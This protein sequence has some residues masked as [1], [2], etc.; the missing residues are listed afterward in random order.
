MTAISPS[1]NSSS[2]DRE[3]YRDGGASFFRMLFR[4]IKGPPRDVTDPGITHE[5]TLI[6][7]LAWVGLG[8]DGLSSSAY[9]P[10]EAFRA[11]LYSEKGDNWYLAVLLALATGFTVLIIS[12]AYSRVIEAFPQGGGG[13]IVSTAL[14]GPK[15]GL[16]S[17]SALIVDYVLTISTS[18]ASGAQLTFFFAPSDYRYLSLPFGLIMVLGLTLLNVRGVKESVQSLLPVFLLFLVTHAIMIVGGI[19]L[20]ARDVGHVF[21]NVGEGFHKGYTSL[22]LLGMAA[23]FARAYSMGAGTY[24]GIEAVSNGVA[25]MREPKVQTAKRTMVYMAFSLA[26]TAT[27]I[28]LLYLLVFKAGKNVATPPGLDDPTP[29]NA[30]LV[31]ALA[32]KFTLGGFHVGRWF[33]WATVFSEVALLFVA[34]QAGFID[35]PRVMASMATDGWLPRRFAA[36]SDRLAMQNGILIIGLAAALL[37]FYADGSVV[38]LVT[39]YAINVFVTFLLTNGGMLRMAFQHRKTDPL[40]RRKVFIH[41]I[42]V[43]LCATILAVTVVEKFT[44]GAWLT[45][46]VTASLVGLCWLIRRHYRYVIAKIAELDRVFAD[47]PREPDAPDTPPPLDPKAP[48]AVL[49]VGGYRGLGIHSFLT[50][51]KMFP[52][53]YKNFIFISV[54][55]VD[56]AALKGPE[57]LEALRHR[58]QAE[59]DKYV[60]LANDA[61]FPATTRMSIGSDVVD[62]AAALCRQLAR[63][64]PR[65]QVFAGKLLF[66][67]EAWY[68][69]ILH[70]ESAFAIQRRLQFEGLTTIVLPVRVMEAPRGSRR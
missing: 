3:G 20:H 61:G 44:K 8:A 45:L 4:R 10:D 14:L 30:V 43:V 66:E 23:I 55:I 29:L 57:E 7:F 67:R 18:I 48:T 2:G 22:G 64:F 32:G 69:R 39:M 49:L 42:C 65:A 21:T 12:A 19:A 40:W 27:G 50:V 24:T 56:S 13:Y 31:D 51:R 37:L 70:N 1:N 9:G 60:K 59:L 25:I 28:L 15:A 53:F 6:A 52:G 68:D 33:V 36:L 47:I 41:G 16:I 38:V 63:E 26:I 35:G 58:T 11:L 62:E 54:A 5:I 46:V 17:G 34:A